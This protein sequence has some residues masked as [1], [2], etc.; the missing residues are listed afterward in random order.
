MHDP[1]ARGE[2]RLEPDALIQRPEITT[3]EWGKGER[4]A[5][6]IR[7]VQKTFGRFG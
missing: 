4:K 2:T 1:R 3:G 7:K 5:T 6:T